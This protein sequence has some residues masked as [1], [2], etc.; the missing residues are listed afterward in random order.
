MINQ[1]RRINESTR[2]D[3]RLCSKPKAN[4]SVKTAVIREER[5]KNLNGRELGLSF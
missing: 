3:M 1:G 2:V 4:R 5:K